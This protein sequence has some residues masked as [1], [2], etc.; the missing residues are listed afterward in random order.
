MYSR[1]LDQFFETL[2]A[3]GVPYLIAGRRFL[4][5]CHRVVVVDH[6]RN[7]FARELVGSVTKEQTRLADGPV[8]VTAGDTKYQQTATRNDSH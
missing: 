4:F 8:S 3:R 1:Q 5:R 6:R 2:L 7:I